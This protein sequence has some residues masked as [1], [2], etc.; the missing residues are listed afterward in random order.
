MLFTTPFQIHNWNLQQHRKL[1][2]VLNHLNLKIHMDM[3]K[4]LLIYLK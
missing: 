3:I 2:T 4:D 1:K